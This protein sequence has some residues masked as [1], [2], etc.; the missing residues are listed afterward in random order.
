MAKMIPK[1]IAHLPKNTTK[2]EKALYRIIEKHTPDDWIC[3]VGYRL[4]VGTTP[5]FL[6]IGPDIGVLVIEEKSIPFHM[7]TNFTMET[8]TVARQGEEQ[9]ETHPL[10]Q[11]RGYVEKVAQSLKRVKRLTDKSG[12]LKFVY[13]HGVV[14]SK[15]RK[16]ELIKGTIEHKILPIETFE[17]AKLICSN[18]LPDNRQKESDFSDRLRK[19]TRF[20]KFDPLGDKDIQTIRGTLFPE[21]KVKLIGDVLFDRDAELK[22]LTV[23]QEQIA[24]GIGRNDKVPHRQ[25]LGVAGSGKTI[26]LRT[27]VFDIAEQYPDWR[28]LVTFFTRALKKFIGAELPPNI[29]VMTIGQSVYQ[30]WI[31]QNLD[32]KSFNISDEANWTRTLKTLMENKPKKDQIYNAIFVDESQDLTPPQADYLR[33]ILSEETNSAFFCG[34]LAQNIFRRKP[35]R[36]ID[37]GFKFKGRTSKLFLSINYRNTASIFNYA[38]SFIKNDIVNQGLRKDKVNDFFKIY[39]DVTLYRKG[40]EVFFQEYKS[41]QEECEAVCQEIFRLIEKQNVSPRQIAIL[42]PNATDKNP[43]LARLYV[44]CLDSK[45][46]G[47]YWISENQQSK[48]NYD[49]RD[50][51]VV[52]STP[53]SGKGLEWEIVFMTSIDKY[54]LENANFLRFVAATRAMEYLHPSA[55]GTIIN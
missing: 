15:I 33:Y 49:P 32:P 35:L 55:C 20:F 42:H 38:Y 24:R 13:S 54:K 36:W 6:L 28:I 25:I 16:D 4:K 11:A 19:M 21:V 10:R 40:S 43:N 39:E 23:E 29:D 41:E 51:H 53:N 47:I 18:E 2:G 12:R 22:S 14:L 50:N 7:I 45:G 37:H 44:N 30:T 34:D 1:D 27:R 48:I 5:D 31:N 52:L 3:Y 8:W 46:I 17:N 9:V 26:M